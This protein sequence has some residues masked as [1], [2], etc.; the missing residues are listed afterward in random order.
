MSQLIL[1]TVNYPFGEAETFLKAELD[2]LSK[3]FERI[4]IVPMSGA[5]TPREVPVNVVISAPL[6]GS[7]ASRAGFYLRGLLSWRTWMFASA[8][9]RRAAKAERR[10]D[11]TL[12]YTVLLWSIYREALERHDAVREA[13]RSP[14]NW[15]AYSYWAHIPSLAVPALAVRGVPC[16][17][18]YH[19]VDLY[20]N[21]MEAAGKFS[22]RRARFFPWRG[23]IESASRVSLFV[24]GHGRSYFRNTW[25]DCAGSTHLV[26]RLGVHSRGMS[27]QDGDADSLTVVSCSFIVP[28]KRVSLIAQF[29]RALAE[30]VRVY[31]HHFGSGD[32]TDL[33]LLTADTSGALT[34]KLW[35]WV[36][37]D[38]I[39][40]FYLNNH[41]DLFVNFS[42]REGIPV[43]IMEALSFGI[44]V[45]ATAVGGTPEAVID[46]ESGLLLDPSEPEDPE[47]LARRVLGALQPAGMIAR[48]RPRDMWRNRFDASR[49]YAE[50]VEI[51]LSLIAK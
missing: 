31:W 37:H 34:T 6:W 20:L 8:E 28:V 24:S 42:T 48:S 14:T 38:T 18:R 46:G 12:F 30:H 16:V 51:F 36:D 4:T 13:G 1:F 22:D 35:G 32:T 25:P 50:L 44:R 5:G 2:E 9:S 7:Q 3:A 26:N 41:V 23:D 15:V 19:S 40:Q 49:N 39:T 27:P 29:V 11:V 10:L 21:G 17:V 43:S 45:A 33:R 47:R